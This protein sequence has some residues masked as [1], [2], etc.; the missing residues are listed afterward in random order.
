MK[1][2]V[3]KILEASE[4]HRW[5]PFRFLILAMLLMQ[6][7]MLEKLLIKDPVPENLLLVTLLVMLFLEAQVQEILLLVSAS[8]RLKEW[9]NITLNRTMKS[10]KIVTKNKL[11]KVKPIFVLALRRIR[12]FP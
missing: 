2:R 4:S 9:L 10:T 11:L 1:D 6:N 3:L 7:I 8:V 12:H 5:L